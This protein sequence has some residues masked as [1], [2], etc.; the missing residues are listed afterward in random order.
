MTKVFFFFDAKIRSAN[1]FKCHSQCIH[2]IWLEL[3]RTERN[4][5]KEKEN[6]CKYGPVQWCVYLSK[7]FFFLPR[8][9][10]RRSWGNLFRRF[11]STFFYHSRPHT[12]DTRVCRCRICV[13]CLCLCMLFFFIFFIFFFFLFSVHW[14]GLRVWKSKLTRFIQNVWKSCR[15]KGCVPKTM[16]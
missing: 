5:T 12:R 7:I 10:R 15:S 13:L 14:R 16:S 2:H 11:F 4:K 6:K 3:N 8:R 1:C 9:S